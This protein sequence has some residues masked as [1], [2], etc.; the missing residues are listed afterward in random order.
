MRREGG[1][2]RLNPPFEKGRGRQQPACVCPTTTAAAADSSQ[3]KKEN[4]KEPFSL[5]PSFPAF[6]FRP[7]TPSFW[8]VG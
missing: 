7:S 3:Q 6:F 4:E 1:N 5:P 8:A 2:N